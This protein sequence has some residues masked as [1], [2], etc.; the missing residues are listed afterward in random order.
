EEEEDHRDVT[1]AP[2]HAGTRNRARS[3]DAAECVDRALAK[4][5]SAM[6]TRS[7]D[8]RSSVSLPLSREGSGEGS[9]DPP[10]PHLP[11]ALPQAGGAT[12]RPRVLEPPVTQRSD[13]PSGGR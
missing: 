11:P 7:V 13:P 10:R 3:E 1:L 6:E 8:A 4:C 9:W 12:S 2:A 5:P